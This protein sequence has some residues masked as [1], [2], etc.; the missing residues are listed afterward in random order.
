MTTIC[1]TCEA[2]RYG[3]DRR[4]HDEIVSM[5]R[6][7]AAPSSDLSMGVGHVDAP[8]AGL[9]PLDV[10]GGRSPRGA[11]NSLRGKGFSSRLAA[12]A[13]AVDGRDLGG[14]VDLRPIG[15]SE[16]PAVAS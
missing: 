1:P 8:C 14:V 16:P 7:P 15:G 4:L 3:D 2:K 5:W 12:S 10:D 9:A 11:L 13:V 6:G